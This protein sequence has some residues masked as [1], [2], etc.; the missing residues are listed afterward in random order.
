MQKVNN[1][2][3][4][5]QILAHAQ[6]LCNAKDDSIT[7]G[8]VCISGDK[9]CDVGKSDE[10]IKRNSDAE[11]VDF[12]GHV[13]APGFINS[14]C[15]SPMGFFRGICHGNQTAVDPNL[16]MIETIFYPAERSLTPELIE[17]LSYSNLV[18]ALKSGITTSCESYF[19]SAGIAKAARKIGMRMFVG[20]H[21]ADLG[22][23]L[24][25]G[26]DTW[27]KF[28]HAIEN[29][30]FPNH[31]H[32][33]VYA[34]AADTVSSSLLRELGEFARSHNLPFHM[35]LSQSDGER[36]R[37]MAREGLSPVRYAHNAGVLGPNSMLVHLISIDDSDLDLLAD[38]GAYAGIT[39]VSEII[40]ERL[41]PI[42]NI[43]SKGIPV[44]LGTDGP[45]SNDSAHMLEEI[46]TF[47]LLMKDRALS[48]EYYSAESALA[49]V[50][51]NP[52]KALGRQDLG[53]LEKNCLADLVVFKSSLDVMPERQI[54][55]N[56]IYS[57]QSRHV[58]HVMV[59]GRWIL[60]DGKLTLV[61]ESDLE[62]AYKK[63]VNTVWKSA[64]FS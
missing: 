25:A 38:S 54:K 64:G 58:N 57:F 2:E 52:A 26:R 62:G 20:E 48:P 35:H 61:S 36:S 16:T 5:K 49:T 53:R 51:E 19:F 45:A 12:R 42:Q 59:G 40:F 7:D 60:W 8:A 29:W 21:I 33:M 50:W 1:S 55:E 41:P 34:H 15:H 24:A 31:I 4:G 56:L 23:P 14:H 44:C 32:P 63:A 46:R 43:V 47:V 37:V 6:V 27:I 9:I 22:G 17:P 11:I 28:R 30:P 39:P 18:D 10:V 3:T 13:L